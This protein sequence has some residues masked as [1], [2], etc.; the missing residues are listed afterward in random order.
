M[1]N[2]VEAAALLQNWDHVLVLSHASP[3]GD[4]LGSAAALLR[5][6]SSL[7]KQVSFC[8]S[9]E[10]PEKFSYLFAGLLLEDPACA[11]HV[12]TVDVADA[13]LLGGL[14]EQYAGKIELAVDHHGTHKPFA[15]RRWV[16]PDSAAAAE[17]VW[18]LL[19][20]LGVTLTPVMASCIYTGLATDTGCFLYRSATPRTHLIAAETMRAGANAGEINQ[21]L[22][23]SKSRAQ[24]A[25]EQ[26]VLSNMEYFCG[27]KC[28]LIQ[29]PR[30]VYEQTGASE[31]DLEGVA[32]LPRQIEGVLLGVTMKER[33]DG[34]IK[35]SLRAA[36]PADAAA[37]CKK[38]GGGGHTGAAGCSFEGLSMGEA[39][40]K[41]KAACEAY[42]RETGLL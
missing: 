31:S 33:E 34:T 6:L 4:T 18:L 30:S 42:L 16:E 37:L 11:Q 14:K 17:L 24:V 22:F 36:P 40:E 29:L 13:A 5:G 7:G 21:K 39:A 12:M 8:C 15:E 32:S 3:D 10:V 25:A 38:F 23:E 20:E 28:A 9:D 19:Q 27:G 2:C 1:L 41:M 35:A 26:L